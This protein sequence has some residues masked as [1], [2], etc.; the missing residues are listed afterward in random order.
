MKMI[1]MLIASVLLLASTSD[2]FGF[3]MIGLPDGNS[4]AGNGVDFNITDDLGGPKELKTFFRWNMPYLTY[5]FDLSFVQYFGIEGMEAVNDAFR[6]INDFFIPEDGSYSGV[7]TM[8]FARD[9]FLSNYNTAWVNTTAQNQ[10]I[11]DL[12]S[13]VLG[14]VVNHIGVGNPHRYAFTIKGIT[15]NTTG[16]QWN[17]NVRLKNYD[18]ITWQPTD[19]IN[20]VTYSY[21]LIHDG[22]ATAGGTLTAPGFADMEEFTTDTSGN[23]WTAVSGIV[24]AFYGN[25]AI[26]WTDSPTLFNFGVYYD[27][28]NAMGGQYKP[29]HALTYDDVGALKYMY[30]TN[31]F[32]YEQLDTAINL[33]T[34]A[35][36][37]KN[38]MAQN[39]LNPQN[40]FVGGTAPTARPPRSFP[41]RFGG[42]TAPLNIVFPTTSPWRGMPIIG[43]VAPNTASTMVDLAMRGGIDKMQFYH[44]P[45]DSLMGITFTA[46]NYAWTDTF[47]TIQGQTISG[48]NNT[49]PGAS[50]YIGPGPLS[51]YTQTVGRTVTAPDIIF[52]ADDLGQ[53]PDGVPI[54]WNRT[55]NA[56]GWVDNAANNMGYVT[57][58][59]TTVGPG[60]INVPAANGI[61]YTFGKMSE[62][63]ELIWSGEASVVGNQETYSLW[64][65]IKGP[66]ANDLVIFPRDAMIWR[67]EN[68]VTPKVSVPVISMLSDN[69]GVS[70]IAT[71][72]YTRTQETISIIGSGLAGGTA[73]EIM[74]GDLVL[75]TL[76]PVE[77]YLV[78]DQ[79]IDIPPGVLTEQTE[80]TARR[81][82]VWNS[83][84]PS[85][86][87]PQFFNIY[88]GRTV[89][90]GT[91]RDGAVFDR[92]QS[93]T[94]YGF[95]F[96]STQGRNADGG[97]KLSHLR[98]EDGQGNV[99]LPTDG[100]STA[101]TWEV[102]SD[103]HAVLTMNSITSAADGTYRRVRV[104]RDNGSLSTLSPTN[105][106]NL[107][108]YITTKPQIDDLFTID[109]GGTR[110][111]IS[112]SVPL[113]RDRAI[114]MN[115][116]A[117]NTAIAVEIVQQDGSSFSNPVV[118]NLPNAGVTVDDNGTRILISS[119]VIP[120]HDADGHTTDQQR[121][122]KLYNAVDNYTSKASESFNVNVQ[123][124]YAGT[125]GFSIPNT[126]NR[127]PTLGDDV[128]II[129][130]GFM[131]VG[132]IQ[133]VDETGDDITVDAN[134][135]IVLPSPGV[136]VTDTS[137]VIDTSIIQFSE[138][139]NADSNSSNRYRRFRLVSARDSVMSTQA[140]RFDI[141]VPPTYV[142]L[143][144]SAATAFADP[145]YLRDGVGTLQFTGTGLGLMV[146]LE[147]V[148]INGN[149]I[150]GVSPITDTTG[151]TVT[152]TQLDLDANA[153]ALTG[154]GHLIDSVTNIDNNG[155]RR[156]KVTTP[157]GVTTST[158][159]D[160]FTISAMPDYLP[161][162]GS[163][164][165]TTTF[166]G[167]ANFNGT[168]A[169]LTSDSDLLVINGSNFRGVG[170]I[171]FQTDNGTSVASINVDPAALPSG[172]MI[173]GAG[174]QMTIR[175]LAI[176][177]ASNSTWIT[178]NATARRL[179]L[180]SVGGATRTTPSII[181]VE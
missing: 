131:A 57:L 91:S 49:T 74:N 58:P 39:F 59:S 90:T 9:G 170:T 181:V 99:V 65:H 164:N 175:K 97:A 116:T 149:P 38:P 112:S 86:L 92:A 140:T 150:A 151:V 18:P 16:T 158:M 154:Q 104:A 55:D 37:L 20:G 128:T 5:S 117:M 130:S 24:D 113:R 165:S 98:V 71:N 31:N 83:V 152:S 19:K 110:T 13:I 142:S 114:E 62:G 72:S 34:P 88:T 15:Q 178:G 69:G 78:S 102:L 48:A 136:T 146:Q 33:I 52:V 155:T 85:E 96:K 67:L 94:V 143:S 47:V 82:R 139:T 121:R 81:I 103:T 7:S 122:F 56:A 118:I 133:I 4:T 162:G 66:G 135:S 163:A 111:A 25:T 95:G 32:V 119:D 101:A 166:A 54:A 3:V 127:H 153:T 107:I 179:R 21:R 40:N 120:Y 106:V 51:Y 172:I 124:V 6:V 45:F 156:I 147:V 148:D 14:M 28:V 100:N 44:V 27:G 8:D 64:G 93:L 159:A 168:S 61:V 35:Q 137:I 75:Q 43:G 12:K 109:V 180:E 73:I 105:N 138:T 79:R 23:A 176:D 1:K 53:A 80:G 50:Q 144:G 11:I 160:G 108:N 132:E 167:S 63:F 89:V 76:F 22:N 10:Q 129:G 134:S 84:G 17:F 26:Y 87:S 169:T 157:F 141:G 68:E 42:A 161:A 177:N 145:N 77:K 123:P 173:N 171:D 125:G 41:R 174:T 46:T 60:V 2:T 115:G 70:A 36:F 126:F 30:R 29:R